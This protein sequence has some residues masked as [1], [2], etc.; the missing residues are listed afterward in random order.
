MEARR[1]KKHT[2]RTCAKRQLAID[3]QLDFAKQSHVDIEPPNVGFEIDRLWIGTLGGS[4]PG[5]SGVWTSASISS[6]SL[7]R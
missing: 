6:F 1:K 7:R 5:A 2:N 4:A 3:S